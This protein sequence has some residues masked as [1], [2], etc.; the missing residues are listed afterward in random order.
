[1]E[2]PLP[3]SEGGPFHGHA[4]I[5]AALRRHRMAVLLAT[6]VLLILASPLGDFSRGSRLIIVAATV[7]FLWAC[8]LQTD[9]VPR[10]RRLV[11][12]LIVLWLI[13]NLPLPLPEGLWLGGAAATLAVVVLAVIRIVAA[14][15]LTA[16]RVDAELLCS[17]IGGYLLLGVFWAETYTIA[18]LLVPGAFATP[19]GGVPGQSTLMYFSFTTLTTTGFGD[20]TALNPMLR[21]W[22]AFEAI[23]GTVYNAT[24]IARL[25][26]LYGSELRR[27]S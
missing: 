11:R 8:L 10:L 13:Q 18:A 1:M 14:R 22:T 24:V 15:M 25:V 27:K 20:I 2:A 12:V 3:D 23:V 16:E 4:R 19:D 17:A 9:W 5:A 26:S 21:M 7:V 6:L